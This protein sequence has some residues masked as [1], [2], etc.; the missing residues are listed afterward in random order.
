MQEAYNIRSLLVHGRK[1][2][3]KV[4]IPDPVNKD[5][6]MHEFID[7]IKN[8]FS[9]SIKFFI[10]LSN[11]KNHKQILNKLHESSLVSGIK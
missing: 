1:L 6:K 3:G 11:T 9:N 4:S 10:K 7:L 8:Y 2:E 5:F